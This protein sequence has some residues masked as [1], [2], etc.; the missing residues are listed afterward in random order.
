[1]G[2]P[3]TLRTVLRTA[4]HSRTALVVAV[5]ATLVI[6]VLTL[7]RASRRD[8]VA[9]AAR[10]APV[11]RRQVR[12]VP[13]ALARTHRAPTSSRRW[14]LRAYAES[15]LLGLLT[16]GHVGAD[17][18]RLHRLTRTGLGRG[19]AVVERGH[20]PGRRGDRPGRVR[21]IRRRGAADASSS[22]PAVGPR[23]GCRSA[24]LVVRRV[25]PAVA[26]QRPR[27][28][29]RASW[30]TACCSP[31]ATSSPSPDSCSAPSRPP[32]T[33]CR[34]VVD[35]RRVRRQPARR[36]RPGSER[37]QPTRRRPR[38]RP[39]RARCPVVAAVAAVALKAA[40]AWLPALVLGGVSLLVTRR[41]P[42]P[43]PPRLRARPSGP[44]GY[45]RLAALSVARW[46]DPTGPLSVHGPSNHEPRDSSVAQL[47]VSEPVRT[48]VTLG[49]PAGGLV[50]LG[51]RR[52][53]PASA[54]STEGSADVAPAHARDIVRLERRLGIQIEAG[55]QDPGRAVRRR[56]RP[57]PTGSTSGDTGR[58]S[59]PR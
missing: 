31:R 48:R 6:P 52:L 16:P 59:S 43:A 55:L 57:S 3:S 46:N 37:R 14:Y 22:S 41:P 49:A 20:G 21:G 26:A 2:L 18:W 30:P 38:G 17:V 25:R 56:C 47:Q 10:P 33:R 27:C 54:G 7:P 24:L 51:H 15:E 4:L 32:A 35:P 8:P 34:P 9:G 23:R 13:A 53:L 29:V 1:M 58:S 40:I 11:D 44:F 42:G 39:G 19:D 12:P 28:R 45:F 36:R 5:I 50:A